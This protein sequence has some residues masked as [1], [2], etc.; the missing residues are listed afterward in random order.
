MSL[1]LH[2][3]LGLT[4][5]TV[6][7][8]FAV[9]AL[10]QNSSSSPQQQQTMDATGGSEFAC[11]SLDAVLSRGVVVPQ[12]QVQVL[13]HQL[14]GFFHH[15]S[16]SPMPEQPPPLESSLESASLELNNHHHHNNDTATT[17]SGDDDDEDDDD[18]EKRMARSRERNREHARRTRQRKKAHLETLRTKVKSLEADR[19]KLQQQIE[20]CSIASIL[21]GLSGEANDPLQDEETKK[22]LASDESK[23]HKIALLTKGKRKR[24]VSDAHD[25]AMD[26]PPLEVEIDGETKYIGSGKDHINW[27]TGVYSDEAGVKSVLTAEQLEML[28]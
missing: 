26:Q 15:N 7:L 6:A 13:P 2:N 16:E 18:Y 28:R 10:Q 1:R 23:S 12:V 9:V 21:I 27:K 25:M 8:A 4:D 3:A 11:A 24:F 19:K 14:Q 20:E 22:L 5:S 17:T